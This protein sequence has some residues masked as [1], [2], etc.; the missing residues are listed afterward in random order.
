MKTINFRL[1]FNIIGS[2]YHVSQLKLLHKTPHHKRGLVQSEASSFFRQ[3]QDSDSLVTGDI[4]VKNR[5]A[6]LPQLENLYHRL[7][8]N[9]T[10][11]RN[12]S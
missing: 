2:S 6:T 11:F 12:P 10:Y 3:I 5:V 8:F 1:L 7:D 9:T 4:Y